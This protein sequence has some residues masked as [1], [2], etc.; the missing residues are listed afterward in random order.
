[1][2]CDGGIYKSTDGG[3]HFAHKN[4]GINSIQ[5]YTIA[6]HPSDPDILY[7][8]A[9]DNGGFSTKNRGATPWVDNV[10]GDGMKC[11]VDYS[12][13]DIVFIATVFGSLS[14]SNDG[15]ATWV[16]IAPPMMDSTAFRS[17]YWQ[18]PVVH[19]II[20]GALKQRI[21]KS[22]DKGNTWFYTTTLPITNVEISA[23]AQ[24]K[25]NPGNMM[26]ITRDIPANIYS[27]IDEGYTWT[28]ITANLIF[29]NTSLM[30]IQADPFDS[31]TFYLLR[32]SYTTGQI[33]KTTDFGNTWTDISSDLPKVPA[34]DIFIDPEI[35]G[36]IFIGNDFGVYHST[37]NGNNW[38]KLDDGFPFVPAIEFSY[39][40]YNGSRLLRAATYGRGVFEMKLKEPSSIN[41]PN[42]GFYALKAWPVPASEQLWVSIPAFAVDKYTLSMLSLN[43]KEVISQEVYTTSSKH[44][45]SMD[46]SGLIP[47]CYQ[48]LLKG[49]RIFQTA[50][51]VIMR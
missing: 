33:L 17:M 49:D 13:P 4:N 20:Y 44:R 9:Q 21:Y 47:G 24:S 10:T 42:S 45:I 34:C 30:N 14:R 50:K 3:M 41:E 11:F 25:I 1:V 40:N 36:E 29:E 38:T 35:E 15:G 7:G 48:L 37:N 32:G 51:V 26:L 16:E 6:S 46:I 43:G 12:N 23:V 2:G 19:N 22:T 8:G 28:D 18:N 39:Y 27:S 31:Q 5:L